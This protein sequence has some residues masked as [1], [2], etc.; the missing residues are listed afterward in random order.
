MPNP[1][2][3]SRRGM[4]RT[5]DLLAFSEGQTQ[6]IPPLSRRCS[7]AVTS[8][9]KRYLA[10]FPWMFKTKLPIDRL[11]GLRHPTPEWPGSLPRRYRANISLVRC[12]PRGD[13]RTRES[14]ILTPA[15]SR[16]VHT[17][18]PQIWWL[19]HLIYPSPAEVFD[20]VSNCRSENRTRALMRS[21]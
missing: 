16:R 17:Q 9:A 4:A 3:I 6:R 1:T 8:R 10:P 20:T 11:I 13:L 12:I 5:S 15:V 7:L 18:T 21:R 14:Q 19:S 2:G